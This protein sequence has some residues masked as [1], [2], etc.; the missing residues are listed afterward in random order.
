MEIPLQFH[1]ILL[2]KIKNPTSDTKFLAS[3]QKNNEIQTSEIRTQKTQQKPRKITKKSECVKIIE[4]PI[5]SESESLQNG[6]FDEVKSHEY[7]LEALNE[8]RSGKKAENNKI[9]IIP[10]KKSAFFYSSEPEWHNNFN[11]DDIKDQKIGSDR[12]IKVKKDIVACWECLV[13]FERSKS[14]SVQAKV[15]KTF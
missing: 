7:F 2:M 9:D 1:Q 11:T 15:R 12:P 13:S 3:T 5:E 4:N 6:V 8:F 10:E 14:L